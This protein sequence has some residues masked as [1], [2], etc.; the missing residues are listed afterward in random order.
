MSPAPKRARSGAGDSDQALTPAE[1]DKLVKR[2]SKET[3][4]AL[5]AKFVA[6]SPGVRAAVEA[7]VDRRDVKPV[8][9]RSYSLEASEIVHSL[10]G[11]RD[12]QQYERCGTVLDRLS[13]LV[14]E[15]KEQLSS[16]NAFAALVAIMDVVQ[17]EAYGEVRKGV[18]MCGGIESNVASE[19]KKL[20]A[21]LS[22][23]EKASISDAVENLEGVVEAL[24]PDCLGDD[25]KQV[26]TL[27]RGN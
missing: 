14:D 15:C 3:A 22:S 24:E 16:T 23:E 17:S 12:S 11:L 10:D 19:L 13:E 4:H 18:L 26:V 5:L 2:L 21:D 6:S 27:V 25:L 7:E 1:C 8:D 20:A 9:L